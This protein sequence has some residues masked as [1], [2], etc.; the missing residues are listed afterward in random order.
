[1]DG[2]R[3]LNDSSSRPR[4]RAGSAAWS[5]TWPAARWWSD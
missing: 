4:N 5:W 3:T 2:L 1:V